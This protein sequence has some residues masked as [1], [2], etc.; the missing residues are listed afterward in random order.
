MS[1]YAVTGRFISPATRYAADLNTAGILQNF[2]PLWIAAEAYVESIVLE[3]A[4]TIPSAA[5]TKSLNGDGGFGLC[6]L[7]E[8]PEGYVGDWPPTGWANAQTNAE[9]AIQYY[10]RPAAD[11]W[12]RTYGYTGPTLVRCTAAEFNAGR[13]AAVKGHDAGNVDQE[14]EGGDYAARVLAAFNSLLTTGDYPK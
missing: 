10:L 5:A 12:Y 7:T 11:W 14:T 2:P 9:F 1:L 4:G 6:Q 13:T 3:I 8:E